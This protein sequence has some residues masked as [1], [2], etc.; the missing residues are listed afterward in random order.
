MAIGFVAQYLVGGTHWVEARSD[1]HPTLWM[2]LGLALAIVTGVG[3]LA[4]GYPFMTTH[5]WH[6]SLPWIGAVH[7]PSATFFDLGVFAVV[8]GAV[9]LLL[10]ALGHQSL[11]ARRAPAPVATEGAG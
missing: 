1:L 3:S 2:A 4:V 11:R 6:F 8:L 10:T 9:L 5:T 7:L